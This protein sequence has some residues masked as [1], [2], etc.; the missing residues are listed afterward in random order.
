MIRYWQ[1]QVVWNIMVWNMTDYCCSQACYVIRAPKTKFR[2]R[3]DF[4]LIIPLRNFV[5]LGSQNFHL[6]SA[7]IHCIYFDYWF[8]PV[9]C[10]CLPFIYVLLYTRNNQPKIKNLIKPPFKCMYQVRTIVMVSGFTFCYKDFSSHL[11]AP[12]GDWHYY[13]SSVTCYYPS[14][15]LIRHF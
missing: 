13:I 8:L 9:E 12:F 11:T 2:N 14:L 10:F 6:F 5:R 15:R 3:F 1:L 7:Y 4:A